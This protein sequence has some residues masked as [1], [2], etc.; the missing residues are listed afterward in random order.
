MTSLV[1]PTTATIMTFKVGKVFTET[2]RYNINQALSGKRWAGAVWAVTLLRIL[3][4]ER[5]DSIVTRQRFVAMVEAAVDIAPFHNVAVTAHVSPA[6][7]T[8]GLPVSSCWI[9]VTSTE[10]TSARLVKGCRW[11]RG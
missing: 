4:S 8:L 9:S 2:N 7:V 1:F 5:P 6:I 11:T 10:V 3:V